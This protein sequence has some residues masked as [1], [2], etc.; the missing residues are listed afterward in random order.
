MRRTGFP[1]LVRTL[2]LERSGG[3]CEICDEYDSDV[4]LHHRRCRGM[5]ST[6][7]PETNMPSNCLALC[8]HCHHCRVESY[9]AEAYD[10][11]WLVRQSHNPA[12]VPVL[13]RGLWVVLDN[14]GGFEPVGEAA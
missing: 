10:N 2:V 14:E 9:R 7:R 11:G 1:P 4:E 13:R 8:A 12:D 5:G 3:R 6:R